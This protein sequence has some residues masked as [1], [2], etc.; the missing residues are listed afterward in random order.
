MNKEIWKIFEQNYSVSL[1]GN[2]RNDET[3]H[4][5]IG[6]KNN[7]GY[8]RIATPTKRYFVHRL[9]AENFIDN[10]ES[11]PVV[12][13]IDGNKL[14]NNISNL[15]WCTHSENDRRVFE[16]NLRKCNTNEQVLEYDSNVML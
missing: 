16:H 9:V 2:V 8:R 13:H 11:K 10:P 12:N 5:L 4:I 7:V 1:F 6:D 3:G 14:N 15:E